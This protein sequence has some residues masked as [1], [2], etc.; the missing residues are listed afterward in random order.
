MA[1]DGKWSVSWTTPRGPMDVTLDLA[2][3]SGALTGTFTGARGGSQN[4]EGGTVEGE[5][6]SWRV[7]RESPMGAITLTFAGKVEGDKISGTVTTPYGA[8]PFSGARA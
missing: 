2:T 4:I 1:I 3:A 6:F 5:S 7:N 8:N